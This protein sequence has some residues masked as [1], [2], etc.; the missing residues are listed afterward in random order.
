MKTI[1]KGNNFAIVW[2]I[3]DSSTHTPFD[4]SGMKVEVGLYSECCKKAIKTYNISNGT[5]EFEVESEELQNGV[6]NLMCRYST[7]NEQ[8]Y[9][10]YKRAFQIT[11]KPEFASNVE[12]I[13]LESKA[14]HIDA[15]DHDDP[16]P[17]FENCQLIAQ[18]LFKENFR[19]PQ[20]T[21]DRAIADE[22][23]NRI[24]DTYVSRE[25]VTKHIRNTYNQQFLENPP[26]ITEGYITPQMLSDETRQLLEESGA[27]INNLPD[28]E[29]LQSVHGVLKL[30]NKQHN[31][32]SYSGLGRQYLRK[33]IVAGQNI[34][35]QSMIQ[36]PN[37]IYI[38]QYD[39]DLNGETIT[40]PENCVLDFQG[41]SL[42]NGTIVGNGTN[43]SSK[44]TL[45]FNDINIKGEWLIPNIYFEWFKW[46]YNNNADNTYTLRNLLSLQ[47][48]NIHNNIYIP[49]VLI[50]VSIHYD[51]E[52][53]ANES[54]YSVG[55]LKSNT[56]LHL[57]GTIKL[58]TWDNSWYS[59]IYAHGSNIN[60]IGKGKI[61]GDYLTHIPTGESSTNKG[62]DQFGYGIYYSGVKKGII[63]GIECN[64]CW[65]DGIKLDSNNDRNDISINLGDP[66]QLCEDILIDNVKCLFNRREG[67]IVE[68]AINTEIRNGVIAYTG[69]IDENLNERNDFVDVIGTKFGID[70][71]PWQSH[72]VNFGTYIHDM[73]IHD[74]KYGCIAVNRTYQTINTR[75]EN[76][77]GKGN[78]LVKS[79][80]AHLDNIDCTELLIGYSHNLLI[81][82]SKL[83]YIQFYGTGDV[84]VDTLI[85]NCKF[86]IENF[87]NNYYGGFLNHHTWQHTSIN[88]IVEYCSFIIGDN[89]TV[90]FDLV[91][92]GFVM[93]NGII[94]NCDIK[95]PSGLGL[96]ANN[97][98]EIIRDC[99]IKVDYITIYGSAERSYN[100][101]NN[102]I[103]VTTED[104]SLGVFYLR[105]GNS[106]NDS[107]SE[108]N[109]LNI[110][111]N[112]INK[113]ENLSVIK[114]RNW[115]SFAGSIINVTGN[116]FNSNSYLG[117]VINV[118][119]A[120]SVI[121]NP[122]TIKAG[123][124]IR[125]IEYEEPGSMYFNN[126]E[127]KI[128][129][130]LGKGERDSGSNVIYL[131]MDGTLN[132]KV[133]LI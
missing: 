9:C 101:I 115:Q 130:T 54:A 110:H 33:N 20:L 68:G 56:T 116:S 65:A 79:N 88:T 75:I 129:H 128:F 92:N 94:K 7:E 10:I 123:S 90:P 103:T 133:T 84:I 111:R 118:I 69:Y 95:F 45:I 98:P 39:Y 16:I 97:L 108:K 22:H 99:N 31:P 1:F 34:L 124:N 87:S 102:K 71:E 2:N 12:T 21:A 40:I 53:Y 74:N 60:I 76:I 25:A 77:T 112:Y 17:D 120:N 113:K 125:D 32:N 91:K 19:L 51:N 70:V 126:D 122:I 72:D 18:E 64:Y 62:A 46:D 8:A 43:L 132:T 52:P 4:F 73:Y 66:S 119:N 13:I 96:S 89:V 3:I 93:K 117:N 55:I 27:T 37:T 104:E 35:T 85:R 11:G 82:N 14:S 44:V 59:I 105:Y 100:F 121:R 58:N 106:S 81:E 23:G 28:G 49:D 50:Y 127:K 83:N 30:A 24:V 67:I 48:V 26:L 38:I 131:N 61:I 57:N 47:N 6:Y 78:Y 15:T 114:F 107:Y 36:W 63:R 86:Y 109:V 42:S 29:D 5:I 80:D 41:G